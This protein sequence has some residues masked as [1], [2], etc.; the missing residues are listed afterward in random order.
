MCVH[1]DV[2]YV[3]YSEKKAARKCELADMD[4]LLVIF[5]LCKPWI[6][7]SKLMFSHL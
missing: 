2:Y 4:D 7:Y 3:R 1:Y 5:T 6:C